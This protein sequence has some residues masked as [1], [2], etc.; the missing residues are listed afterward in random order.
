VT[1]AG[2][3]WYAE[4]YHQQYLHKI[5]DGYCPDHGT[6]VSCALAPD[7]SAPERRHGF[8]GSPSPS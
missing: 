5:P 8:G 2:P 4:G 3:F 7:R 1:Q 6:G